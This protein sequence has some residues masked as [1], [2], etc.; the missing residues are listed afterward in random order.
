MTP[1][2]L[3]A[4]GIGTVYANAFAGPLTDA[5]ERFA[6][7]PRVQATLVG[8]CVIES[9]GFRK[10]EENLDYSQAP[11]IVSIFSRK[12]DPLS[13]AEAA[14]LV[15]NPQALANRVYRNRYGNGNEASGDG[16]RFRG[17]GLIALTFQDNYLAA[18]NALSQPYVDTPEL[19]STPTHA[20]LVAAWYF[21]WRNLIEPATNG[22]VDAVT[23]GINAAM[24]KAQE[25]RDAVGAALIAL[26][27]Q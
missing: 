16:W 23:R 18:A 10:L 27:V 1:E 9:L 26:G 4:A 2:Q 6:L 8:E 20:A 5:C 17:R 15:G 24:L 13:L 25:R 12:A 22:D 3:V 19:V 21:V 14:T 11:R 7:P